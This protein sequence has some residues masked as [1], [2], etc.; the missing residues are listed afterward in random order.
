[1]GAHKHLWVYTH[2]LRHG[3]VYISD[4]HSIIILYTFYKN[5]GHSKLEICYRK[6]LV[7]SP[8]FRASLGNGFVYFKDYR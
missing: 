4:F 5:L 1:M 6:F 2:A 3:Y 7:S 8:A